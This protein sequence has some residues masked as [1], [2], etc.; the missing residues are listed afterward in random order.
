MVVDAEKRR[1][2]WEAAT[3]QVRRDRVEVDAR[4]AEA[5]DLLA[6]SRDAERR[7]HFAEAITKSMRRK[8]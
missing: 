2:A 6:Q 5:A 3:E 7:N 4:R 8:P 1:S